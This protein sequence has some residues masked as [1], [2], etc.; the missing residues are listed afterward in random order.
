MTLLLLGPIPPESEYY[1]E[2]ALDE[3]VLAAI[4]RGEYVILRG[5]RQT[6]KTS[7]ALRLRS[8]LPTIGI[9]SSLVDLSALTGSSS[10][11]Q[12]LD[13][14]STSLQENFLPMHVQSRFPISPARMTEL[15]KYILA[16][17]VEIGLD[18]PV[19]IFLDEVTSVP[20][21]V[22]QA[23]FATLRATYS[24]RSDPAA[25]P[26][27]ARIQFVFIGTFNPVTMILG[28]NSPFNVARDFDTGEFDYTLAQTSDLAA[29]VGVP[30]QAPAAFSLAGGHPYLTN[31][32]LDLLTEGL[33]V[34]SARDE[35]LRSDPN[36]RHI[37]SQ[38]NLLGP[39]VQD[40]AA[41]ILAGD[42]IYFALS[43]TAP[44]DSLITLGLVKADTNGL[45]RIRCPLYS[46]FLSRH[47]E[48]NRPRQM[49][50][51]TR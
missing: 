18:W 37:G 3:S 49:G 1:V 11:A 22:S 31:R 28:K 8:A 41:R 14:F 44:L 6:G 12:W 34:E 26:S 20:A 29:K 32:I 43:L 9:A 45:A 42:E 19:V 7:L 35:I 46:E 25:A 47:L 36:L 24:L 40:L 13:G 16:I 27:A 33:T 17:P 10:E 50:F 30:D 38:L 5:A 48:Q 51:V 2:R 4:H 15:Q 21:D 39:A 23:F